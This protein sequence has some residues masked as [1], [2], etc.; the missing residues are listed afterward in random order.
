MADLFGWEPPK[1][2]PSPPPAIV[3]KQAAMDQVEKNADEDWKAAMLIAVKVTAQR[4]RQFTSDDVFD[5]F[6]ELG[7]TAT[8]HEKRA[9]GPVMTEAA[10]LGY[11]RKADCAPR[12]SRRVS[13]HAAPLTV[14]D[15]LIYREAAA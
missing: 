2:K 14:W 12:L 1:R 4:M 3:A 11:C 5:T 7:S 8:T 15:S 13:R 10:K 6:D 9:F